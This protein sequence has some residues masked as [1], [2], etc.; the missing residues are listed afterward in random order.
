MKPERT[1][2][3]RLSKKTW[4]R[5]RTTNEQRRKPQNS[6]RRTARTMDGANKKE[7]DSRSVAFSAAT[8][9]INIIILLNK[10]QK[11]KHLKFLNFSH[12]NVV[13]FFF[14]FLDWILRKYS[15]R[16]HVNSIQYGR[17]PQGCK[18]KKNKFCI[19]KTKNIWNDATLVI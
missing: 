4:K 16:N 5:R 8:R 1:E 7:R 12:F 3:F 11:K 17:K 2:W 10:Q 13:H 14:F 19:A 18:K 15:Y 9:R 6:R